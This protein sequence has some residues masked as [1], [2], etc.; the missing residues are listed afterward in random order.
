MAADRVAR[1]RVLKFGSNDTIGGL[2]YAVVT[3]EIKLFWNNFEI[4][5]VFYF[6]RN[7]VWNSNW[8]KIIS[9]AEGV[10]GLFQNHFSDSEHVGKYSWA[11]ISLWNNFE[12]IS[13][14]YPRAE[15]K[16][17]QTEVDEGWNDFE[18]ILFHM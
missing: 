15:I 6:T 5:S 9:A 17:L 7:H 10:L 2:A 3:C 18:V 16:L 1:S 13:G 8:N 4:I 12:I 11:V 14:M